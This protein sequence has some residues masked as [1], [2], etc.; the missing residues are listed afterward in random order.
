MVTINSVAEAL[1]VDASISNA[2][3]HA[4]S[5]WKQI[6]SGNAP[7]LYDKDSRRDETMKTLNVA[8]TVAN[9]I[10]KH[11]TLE[12]NLSVDNGKGDERGARAEYLNDVMQVVWKNIRRHTEYAA[13]YGGVA[14]K[15]YNTETGIAVDV[16]LADAFLPTRFNARGDVTGAI[17][18][19]QVVRGDKYYTKLEHHEF[20]PDQYTIENRAFVSTMA[21]ELGVPIELG[22]IDEW[23]ELAP[24]VTLTGIKQPLFA[25]FKMPFANPIDPL[26]PL[27]V[28]VFSRAIGLLQDAD[29]QYSRVLWEYEGS[30]LAIDADITALQLDEK[31]NIQLP[32]RDKRLFRN[33]RFQGGDTTGDFY[34]VFN[35]DIRDDSLFNGLNQILRQIE[36]ACG[37][38]FGTLADMQVVD[39]TATEVR[40]TKQD[41][42]TTITDIQDNLKTAM[43]QLL[44]AVN[45]YVDLYGLAP[46]GEYALTLM[47]EDGILSDPDAE[48]QQDMQEVRD[49][50]LAAWEYRVKWFGETEDEAKRM[51]ESMSTGDSLSFEGA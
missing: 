20:A 15:P 16:V 34:K 14:F 6:Y 48:R 19:E 28:S 27:G 9:K 30:E 25:Y 49:K 4:I 5:Q 17:F 22:V 18:V 35:P 8:A 37:L 23:S 44:T 39:R 1:D 40:Y 38:S 29:E 13:A 26:S 33:T 47:F 42:Y 11:V 46:S 7:W 2:M 21:N 10:A 24:D 51:I 43:Q 36:T 41:M 32:A 3:M 45:A 12:T 50:L 31:G